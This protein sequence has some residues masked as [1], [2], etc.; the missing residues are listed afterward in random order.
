MTKKATSPRVVIADDHFGI[1]NKV[2]DLLTP[3]FEVTERAS[4]GLTALDCVRRLD[5]DIALLDL[6]MPGM[7]GLY[8]VRTLRKFSAR[9]VTVIMSSDTDPELAKTA[10]AAGALGFVTKSRLAQDLLPALRRALQGIVFVSNAI[11]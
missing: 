7:S 6:H 8:I 11:L 5:P 1:L 9:T 2:A 10:I 4:D 3:E